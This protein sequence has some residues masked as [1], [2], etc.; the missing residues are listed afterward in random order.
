VREGR[1]AAHAAA[2][3]GRIVNTVGCPD[4]G[5]FGNISGLRNA[6]VVHLTKTLA[7]ELGAYGIHVNLVHP[8]Q[9]RPSALTR[10]LR[11]GGF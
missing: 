11:S 8:G 3:V 4:G 10:R 1:R 7:D 9:T 2:E 6:A 5:G